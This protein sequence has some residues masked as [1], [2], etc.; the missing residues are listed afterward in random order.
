MSYWNFC[1]H[2]FLVLFHIYSS[3]FLFV[4]LAFLALQLV[5]AQWVYRKEIASVDSERDG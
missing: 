3:L 4:W 2:F 5:F 1:V